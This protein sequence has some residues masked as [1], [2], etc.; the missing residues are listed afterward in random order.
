MVRPDIDLAVV[1]EG[2]VHTGVR[3][4]LRK[5]GVDVAAVEEIGIGIAAL[6]RSALAEWE[7]GAAKLV[8]PRLAAKA[9]GVPAAHA[10]PMGLVHG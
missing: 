1:V 9:V 10:A 4:G 2:A 3:I 6:G 7:V 8:I 5:L